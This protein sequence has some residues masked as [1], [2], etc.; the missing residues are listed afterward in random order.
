LGYH[1]DTTH[2]RLTI[3]TDT[4]L[5]TIVDLKRGEKVLQGHSLWRAI[6]RHE[7]DLEIPV[8]TNLKKATVV[9]KANALVMTWTEVQAR[10]QRI[11]LYV[12]AKVSVSGDEFIWTCRVENTSRVEITEL[13]FPWLQVVASASDDEQLLWPAG[14]GQRIHS[15]RQRLPSR[16]FSNYRG[17]DEDGSVYA[18]MYPGR[19]CMSWFGLY[20]DGR[21]IYVASYDP[22]W[23]TTSLAVQPADSGLW[24]GTVKYLFLQPGA[25][26]ASTQYV[27]VVH[28]SDWHSDAKRYRCWAE[29]TWWQPPRPHERA[30]KFLGWQR[31]ILRH[32]YGEVL[33]PYSTIAEQGASARDAGLDTLHL[34]G[35]W[36]GGMDNRYPMYEYGRALGTR[37]E[38]AAQ[39]THLRAK[40]MHA[41]LY[42]T[43][44][45]IDQGTPFYP[46]RG[47]DIAAKSIWGTPYHEPYNFW[48]TG[49]LIRQLKPKWFAPA[50]PGVEE[51][52]E[53]IR[54]Q[55][56]E[57]ISLGADGVLI[58]Q[59]GGM[60]PYPCFDAAH[61]HVSPALAAGP[62]KVTHMRALQDMVQE[63]DPG[64]IFATEHV[65]D[66]YGQFFDVLH[67][68]GMG[69]SP[70]A[71]GFPELFRYTFPEYVI[72]NRDGGYDERN[73]AAAVR[74]ACL[75]GL[76][77]DMSVQRGRRTLRTMP[78]YAQT[79]AVCNTLR[80]RYSDSL[81][82][83]RFED[84]EGFR[85]TS[86][87]VAKAFRGCQ[88][89]G[90]MV[91]NPTE[92]PLIPT[93]EADGELVQAVLIDGTPYAEHRPLQPH[94]VAYFHFDT[95]TGE[96]LV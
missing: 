33:F 73:M 31:T 2:A 64:F 44:H 20:G 15:P 36:D 28:D 57:C 7:A 66:V 23:R 19:A 90:L 42:L 22:T 48:G 40:G 59:I 14:L 30:R 35:W 46:E 43:G 72:T 55:I 9:A 63:Y 58:D 10:E 34:L 84:N 71:E 85:V 32:Q 79:L 65:T 54:R 62:N 75:Y 45:L 53:L 50:C 12:Q 24:L 82:R 4:G 81:L 92:E 13:W 89:V 1:L 67:S 6:A 77:F 70:H 3:D 25:E 18:L 91:W 21:G 8:S 38:L 76:R 16:A 83:G 29:Q 52:W 61:E 80:R 49:S 26:W 96:A 11:P 39:L 68:C 93:V 88:S 78:R 74:H 87:L 17:D 47:H 27:M 41:I 94:E 86:G 69:A 56:S 60:S 37:D 95:Q 5:M 51:W